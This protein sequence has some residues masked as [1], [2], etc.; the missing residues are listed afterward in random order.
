MVAIRAVIGYQ[1]SNFPYNNVRKIVIFVP[2]QR[3]IA[4]VDD[5]DHACFIVAWILGALHENRK[6]FQS[7]A[8]PSSRSLDHGCLSPGLE[9][10]IN[11][12]SPEY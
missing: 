12:D 2:D 7:S 8:I 9:F 10:F 4:T 11:T 6:Q 1:V 3:N 5:E